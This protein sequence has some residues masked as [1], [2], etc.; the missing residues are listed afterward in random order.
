MK[1]EE[2]I[3]RVKAIQA[4]MVSIGIS[5]NEDPDIEGWCSYTEKAKEVFKKTF[6][7]KQKPGHAWRTEKSL[8]ISPDSDWG[9]WTFVDYSYLNDELIELFCKQHGI[10]DIVPDFVVPNRV[11]PIGI[12]QDEDEDFIV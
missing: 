7:Y 11:N 2:F 9:Y 10:Y 3:K 12:I 6:G 5:G 4:A 8:W 1:L